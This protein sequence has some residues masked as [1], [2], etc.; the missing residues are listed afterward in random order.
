MARMV[1]AQRLHRHSG[2]KACPVHSGLSVCGC[3]C[4]HN[5]LEDVV[6]LNVLVCV[7]EAHADVLLLVIASILVALQLQINA[8]QSNVLSSYI[9]S[10]QSQVSNFQGSIESKPCD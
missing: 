10:R 3:W 6:G 2:M 7:K 1:S 8:S 9:Q 4:R 5:R